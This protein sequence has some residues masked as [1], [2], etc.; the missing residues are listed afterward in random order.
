MHPAQVTA[1][2]SGT[3]LGKP[4][5]MAEITTRRGAQHNLERA[6]AI[7]EIQ[8][9]ESVALGNRPLDLQLD[10]FERTLRRNDMMLQ[11]QLFGT[12]SER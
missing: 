11:S 4:S 5:R 2:A 7:K 1:D 3:C 12:V 9:R 10:L 8:A 6:Q